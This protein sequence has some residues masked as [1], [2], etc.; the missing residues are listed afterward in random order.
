[1]LAYVNKL[2]TK[3]YKQWKN[4]LHQ[5][6]ETFDDPQ[7]FK[8]REDNWAWLCSHFQEL[9]YVKKAKANKSNREKMNLLHYS[10]LRPFSY[11]MEAQ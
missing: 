4:N 11:R 9:G 8:D 10:G 5:Y 6:F 7:E 1:M 2:F 3:R